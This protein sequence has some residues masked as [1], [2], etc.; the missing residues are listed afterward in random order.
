MVTGDEVGVGVV[1]H[2]ELLHGARLDQLLRETEQLGLCFQEAKDHHPAIGSLCLQP[3]G[4][5]RSATPPSTA[6]PLHCMQQTPHCLKPVRTHTT[7]VLE[8][9]GARL[10]YCMGV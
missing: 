3:R 9:A 8:R 2:R 4:S 10:V 6:A 7:A 1:G 5:S